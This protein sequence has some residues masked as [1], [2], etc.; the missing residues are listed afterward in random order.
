MKSNL[1]SSRIDNG[2]DKSTQLGNKLDNA[3]ILTILLLA[4]SIAL[5][6]DSALAQGQGTA[7]LEYTIE[8]FG[9]PMLNM[10]VVAVGIF[11]FFLRF[12]F[13][14]IGTVAGGGLIFANYAE[15]AGLFGGGA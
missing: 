11:M 5:S 14:I 13:P 8:E 6:P 1:M 2:Q 4:L 10:A 12:S 7:L 9:R 3:V 15:I